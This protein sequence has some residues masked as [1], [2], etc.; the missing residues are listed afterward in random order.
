MTHGSFGFL[1]GNLAM[2]GL[3]L[4]FAL[5]CSVWIVVCQEKLTSSRSPDAVTSTIGGLF[6]ETV[7][8]A[9]SNILLGSF[10]YSLV[11]MAQSR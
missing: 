10:L 4:V 3:P 11:W 6:G 2:F 7:F 8:L 5:G 1:Q 9:I